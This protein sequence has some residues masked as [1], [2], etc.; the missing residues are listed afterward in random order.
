MDKLLSAFCGVVDSLDFHIH[1]NHSGLFGARKKHSS[2][3][4]G[5]QSSLCSWCHLYCNMQ[6]WACPL[7]S[8]ALCFCCSALWRK[9]LPGQL[10]LRKLRRLNISHAALSCPA[11]LLHS[12]LAMIR[13]TLTGIKIEKC[14]AMCFFMNGFEQICSSGGKTFESM[15]MIKKNWFSY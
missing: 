10:F 9:H 3:I 1:P 7:P 11:R 14:W 8:T 13:P 12:R 6:P 15:K 5:G 4:W 2:V